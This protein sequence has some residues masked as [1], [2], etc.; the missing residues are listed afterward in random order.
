MADYF[1]HVQWAGSSTELPPS[2]EVRSVRL[3]HKVQKNMTEIE[4][5]TIATTDLI[6][7]LYILNIYSQYNF[8]LQVG[9]YV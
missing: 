4:N 9:T 1:W 2:I 6:K 5:S 7:E 8:L 3:L